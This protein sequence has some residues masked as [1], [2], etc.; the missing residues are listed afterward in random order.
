MKKCK[1]KFRD[2]DGT[3][4]RLQVVFVE[5]FGEFFVQTLDEFRASGEP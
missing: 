3:R 1:K 2:N 4:R 5:I